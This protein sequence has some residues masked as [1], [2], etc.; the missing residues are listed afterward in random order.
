MSHR[1][2]GYSGIEILVVL[3][4]GGIL[5]GMALPAFGRAIARR[6]V[7]NARDALIVMGARAR[8]L[9]IERGRAVK[10]GVE[11]AAGRA[12]IVDGP[13]TL[14]VLDYAGEFEADLRS[15]RNA[16]L[17]EVCFTPR[18]VGGA[19][20]GTVLP[21]TVV[22]TRGPYTARAAIRVLGQVTKP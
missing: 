16:A 8:S 10:L 9:A 6:N 18:G 5:A 4:I 7:E 11:T 17:L 15:V 19:C 3:V 2:A 20:G 14:Q 22:F 21:D 1:L 13:D 12:W